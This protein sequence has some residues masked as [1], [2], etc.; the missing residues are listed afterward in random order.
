MVKLLSLFCII[1]VSCNIQ[2]DKSDAEKTIEDS[3]KFID[4]L[5]VAER[6]DSVVQN[7]IR[8]AYFDTVGISTAPIKVISA[9]LVRREYSNLKDIRLV[10]KNVSNKNIGAIKFKWYGLNAFNEPADMGSNYLQE[11][12]GGGFTDRLLKPGKSDSGEWSILS[13]DGKKVVL[14]W[15]YEVAFEDG[16]K[17]KSSNR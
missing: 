2:S 4:S 13:K 11:G 17:W 9:K 14:A 5:K 16:T 6:V 3:Q 15:P 1:L 8:N 12:F 10:W 7:T